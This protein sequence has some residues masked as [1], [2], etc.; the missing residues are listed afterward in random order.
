MWKNALLWLNAPFAWGI[1]LAVSLLNVL[2]GLLV[3][4]VAVPFDANRRASL[5]VNRWIW[6]HFL[7]FCEPGWH[8]RREGFEAVTG[9]PYI[10]VSN[11]SSVLDIPAC[12]G[13][14]LPLRVVGRSTLF[15][16]PLLGL[17]MR[18]S[19]QISLDATSAADVLASLDLCKGALESGASVLI[20]PEGTRSQDAQLGRFHRG[21]F[22]LA[23]DTGIPI[24][25]VAILGTHRIMRKGELLPVGI[26]EA[27]RMRVLAPVPP[28]DATTARALGER[29][30]SQ[31]ESALDEL[32]NQAA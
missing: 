29:V 9:G 32:R 7:W 25:P 24:L 4:L 18:F 1:F 2:G 17:Y 6:G 27:V 31:L 10:V 15:R 28:G 14:P 19:R 5:W 3:Q 16:I 12:M 26:S 30:R 11:H 23:L 22:R 21:A 13:L 8:L 20:F